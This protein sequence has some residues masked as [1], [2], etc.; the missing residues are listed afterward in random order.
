MAL[1]TS[2]E[3]RLSNGTG[4]D[5]NCAV[6]LLLRLLQI[7]HLTLCAE[8]LVMS[9]NEALSTLCQNT[10]IP[11]PAHHCLK[12]CG[13]KTKLSPACFNAHLKLASLGCT[14]PLSEWALTY[15]PPFLTKILFYTSGNTIQ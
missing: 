4:R 14:L 3:I 2:T 12:S 8:Y 5:R 15:F 10:P 9:S 1:E 7:S 6:L 13:C 11:R